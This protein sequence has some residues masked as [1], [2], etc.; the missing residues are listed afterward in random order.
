MAVPVP[1]GDPSGGRLAQLLDTVGAT[2]IDVLCAPR[3]LDI[4][5][6]EPVIL[7]A[8]GQ[9]ASL[10]DDLLLAVGIDLD[11]SAAL[12]AIETARRTGAC[13]V[14]LKVATEVP[15]SVVRA[16]AAAGVALFGVSANTVWGHLLTLL[17]TARGSLQSAGLVAQDAV[18]VD[19]LFGLANAIAATL[20]GATTIEDLRWNVLA[21]STLP[22]PIDGPRQDTILGHR[23]PP[24]WSRVLEHEG[25]FQRLYAST[26]V[27]HVPGGQRPCDDPAEAQHFDLRA[28][29]AIAV[30]A[31]GEPLGSI[32]VIE[33]DEPFTASA[34]QSLRSAAQIAA[35]HLLHHRNGGDL[36]RQRRAES[37]RGLLTGGGVG[38]PLLVFAPDTPMCVV[39]FAPLL[40]RDDETEHEL[41]VER[42][43]GLLALHLDAH[44][45]N[46]HVVTLDNVVYV[47][48]AGPDVLDRARLRDVVDELRRYLEHNGKT[49]LRVGIGATVTQTRNLAQS[50]SDA[51]EV[52]RVLERRQLP[53]GDVEEL[54][55]IIALR[56]LEDT[57]ADDPTLRAGKVAV[58]A[59][60]DE[61]YGTT[62]I[63]TLRAYLDCFGDVMAAA[64]AVHVH[65]NTFRYR[66][67]R[68]VEIADLDLEDP[69]ER[70]IAHLQ[71][72]AMAR[73]S[74]G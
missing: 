7:D 2:L 59:A 43:A 73:D 46:A 66:L 27:V 47:L 16:A 60:H 55:S 33:G 74:A 58:L 22:Q 17:R 48:W 3:G 12:D 40:D 50:R 37:L 34:A 61:E 15:E 26:D 35:M 57:V 25:V 13:G 11:S 71:L 10:P 24:A 6:G 67:A 5:V 52:L 19:D 64:S 69:D 68:L 70:L 31:G 30:R 9:A 42:V 41:I 72:H 51:D 4:P 38:A 54:R 36:D 65:R 56:R 14:V 20:G 8:I 29:L 45:R 21:Y 62:H 1:S 28:R 49:T 23:V 39:A 63:A 53:S 32:W 44:R 18:R